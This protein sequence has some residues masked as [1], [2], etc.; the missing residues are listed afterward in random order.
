MASKRTHGDVEISD[1]TGVHLNV[2]RTPFSVPET[3]TMFQYIGPVLEKK[4]Q[5]R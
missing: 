1:S 3:E 4:Q 5:A 2:K